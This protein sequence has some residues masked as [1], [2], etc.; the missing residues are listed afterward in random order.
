MSENGTGYFVSPEYLRQAAELALPVKQ[1]SYSELHLEN[2]VAIL[3]AGCGPA[4][5]TLPLS[6][7]VGESGSVIGIDLD[8]QMVKVANSRTATQKTS[9]TP[10]HLQGAIIKLPFKNDHFDGCRCE[11]VFQ[12][13]PDPLY[14]L[15][16]LKRVT[17]NGGRIVVVDTDHSTTTADFPDQDLGWILVR[18]QA[19][20]FQ[21]G[22]AGRILYRLFQ[23]AGI[24]DVKT[25]SFV[26]NTTSFELFRFA[27]EMNSL[28]ALAVSRN[29]I[30]Q[31]KADSFL[32]N[33]QK[34]D[35]KKMFFGSLNMNVVS[36]TVQK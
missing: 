13:L 17:K 28:L 1:Y 4:I 18:L 36:G 10:K 34:R 20:R 8:F 11:R 29:L 35:E 19:E 24:K 30:S 31:S 15:Q 9:V 21:C 14:A 7:F 26:F 6:S 32:Q 22:Y 27:T 23:Q 16:E 3:D 25:K 33:L 2:N 12:H 5:D